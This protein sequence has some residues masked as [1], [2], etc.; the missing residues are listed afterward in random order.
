ML[1]TTMVESMRVACQEQPQKPLSELK[2]LCA[3]G[4]EDA[5]TGDA[6]DD[7]PVRNLTGDAGDKD[8]EW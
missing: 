2:L 7:G 3:L 5:G 1:E 4:D 6:S 8:G